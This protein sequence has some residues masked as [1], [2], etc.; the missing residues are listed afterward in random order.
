M[1]RHGFVTFW[2]WLM[3]IVNVFV[4]IFSFSNSDFLA[5]AYNH[6]PILLVFGGLVSVLYCISAVLILKWIN[7]FWLFLGGNI[8]M[9]FIMIGA[10]FSFLQSIFLVAIS[11]ILLF[12]VL[13]LKKNN[14]STWDY[15]Q[16]KTSPT[17]KC[18]FCANEIKTEAIIC[19]YCGKDIPVPK[20]GKIIIKGINCKLDVNKQIRI[21]IDNKDDYKLLN[22]EEISIDI[23]GGKHN[24]I[25]RY[26]DGTLYGAIDELGIEVDNNCIIINITNVPK[27]KIELS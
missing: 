15:L 13:Q 8:A 2:L 27:L 20:D 5:V 6:N 14:I 9:I 11:A 1:E 3:I 22:G 26:D 25:A 12:G 18:P 10:D 7:G 19:Q 16:G 21:S 4:V 24:L 17:K 23:K